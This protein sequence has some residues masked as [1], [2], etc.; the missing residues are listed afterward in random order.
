MEQI[1]NK[2]QRFDFK[3]HLFATNQELYKQI[4]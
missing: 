4:V 1:E 3:S 2:K